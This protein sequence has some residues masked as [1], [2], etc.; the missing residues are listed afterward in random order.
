[1]A[2]TTTAI[3]AIDA[4]VKIDNAAG[5]LT[6]ISGSSNKVDINLSNG[7]GE[8][9]N[10]TSQ[11]KGRL[12][13]GKDADISLDV[14]YTTTADEAL[15]LLRDLFF[16]G[17]DTPRS[18]QID[19]PDSSNGSD[20]YTAEVVLEDLSIPLDA[21]ADEVVMCSAT[22]KPNGAVSHATIST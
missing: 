5:T 8:F 1:M 17:T 4:V 2:Q 18:I 16:G 7:V 21:G 20:R 10:F 15:D 12:V 9:R 11:W 6:D 14:V 13:V 19:V 3:S 22:L